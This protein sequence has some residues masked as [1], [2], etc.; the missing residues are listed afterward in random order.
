MRIHFL[1]ASNE[2][3]SILRLVV[4]YA[5]A[6]SS[7]G[8][9]VTV[10][11]PL[12]SFWDHALWQARRASRA[13]PRT[14]RAIARTI[15]F[16]WFAV[17]PT[18]RGLFLR[19]VSWEGKRRYR[20]D[21]RV[22]LNWFFVLPNASNMPDADATILLQNYFLLHATSLLPQKGRIIGSVHFDCREALM[23]AQEYSRAWAS[24]FVRI[25]RMFDVPRFAVSPSVKESAESLG[26]GV[27]Q[28]IPNGINHQEFFPRVRSN[29]SAGPLM[30]MLFCALGFPKGQDF[31]ASVVRE[32]KQGFSNDRV[33]FVSIGAVKIEYRS[34]FHKNLGYLSGSAYSRA[35]QQAD[36]FIYPSLRDGWPAPP[37]EAMA[38]GAALC[39]TAVQ[40]VVGYGVHGQNMLLAKPNDLKQMVENVRLLIEDETLRDRVR[41]GGLETVKQY[42]WNKSAA[43]LLEFLKEVCKN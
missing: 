13:R 38:C 32:L 37:L 1:L 40:G 42:R 30:V 8:A 20:L 14:V 26:I 16:T 11:Y 36:I 9:E 4:E 3:N 2:E 23:D 10:S 12:V 35:L 7:L 34:L 33:R 15:A 19:G 29:E 27:D 6:L 5:N 18:V 43:S 24:E 21:P 25:E 22:R 28:V 31:G 17:I 39:S 41:S